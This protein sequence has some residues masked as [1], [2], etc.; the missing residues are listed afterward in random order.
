MRLSAGRT[1]IGAAVLMAGILGLNRT[2]TVAAD[3][4]SDAEFKALFDQDVKNI[5]PMI[6]KG[7]S[8]KKAEISKASRSVKSNAM[9]IAFY[10]NSRIGGKNAT[11]DLKMAA[12]RDT[13]LIVALDSGKKNFKAA[14]VPAAKLSLDIAV[15]KGEAKAMDVADLSK[16]AELDIEELMYQFKKI[17]VG[18]LGIEKEIKDN[19]KKPA[20]NADKMSALATRVLI[21]ADYS[22]EVHV[23][24][25]AKKTKKAWDGFNKDM[26]TAAID[27]K[28][29]AEVK[30]KKKLQAAFDKLDR[31]CTACHEVMK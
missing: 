13:A 30:D 19:A 7:A 9:M 25:D 23:A 1:I 10:A 27:L 16:K 22:E 5:M 28:K 11:E 26:R 15:N 6:E 12:L 17:E 21:V 20:L 24:F 4:L 18:G 31:S 29:A 2:S 8:G 14:A 3:P